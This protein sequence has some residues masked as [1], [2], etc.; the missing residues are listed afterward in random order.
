MFSTLQHWEAFLG[1][2]TP[3]VYKYWL[4]VLHSCQ[5][6]R[7][8]PGL[9][10]GDDW[11]VSYVPGSSA[12]FFFF[13]QRITTFPWARCISSSIYNLCCIFFA[14]F[15]KAVITL[16]PIRK[17][18]LA[19]TAIRSLRHVLKKQIPK[20]WSV[21]MGLQTFNLISSLLWID[22][23]LSSDVFCVAYN[24]RTG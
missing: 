1:K 17:R 24:L 10:N 11:K 14:L 2:W 12:I 23:I 22:M 6:Y 7:T 5:K 18:K 8:F 9:W 20:I 15:F 4:N 21:E 13:F 3:V 16:F 19:S